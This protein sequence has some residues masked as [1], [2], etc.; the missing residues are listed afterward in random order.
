MDV[1]GGKVSEQTLKVLASMPQEDARA[2][3]MKAC[4]LSLMHE[5]DALKM[6]AAKSAFGEGTVFDEVMRCLE[7]CF[8]LRPDLVRVAALDSDIN[9]EALKEVLKVWVL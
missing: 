1:Y 9:E 6:K 8:A 4:C 2:W 3:Y 5:N 7:E